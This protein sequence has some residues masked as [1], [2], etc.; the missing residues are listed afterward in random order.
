MLP[1]LNINGRP[2]AAFDYSGAKAYSGNLDV[3]DASMRSQFRIS[4]AGSMVT[5]WRVGELVG[6]EVENQQE[7]FDQ[8]RGVPQVSE[9][10]KATYFY[11]NPEEFLPKHENREDIRAALAEMGKDFDENVPIPK[12][13]LTIP[14]AV[15][16]QENYE[17]EKRDRAILENA[18]PGLASFAATLGGGLVGS[19]ADPVNFIPIAN[20]LSKAKML[21]EGVSIFSRA[22]LKTLARSAAVGAGEGA[23]GALVSDAAAFPLANRWGAD[24]G[25]EDL[26]ADVG[27]GAVLGGGLSAG[28]TM[29]GHLSATWGNRKTA[30]LHQDAM[31]K[32]AADDEAGRAVDVG[33][34]MEPAVRASEE[35]A[36]SLLPPE[37]E[38]IVSDHPH[39]WSGPDR[40]PG[41]V[42]FESVRPVRWTAETPT[43]R[44]DFGLADLIARKENGRLAPQATKYAFR[45]NRGNILSGYELPMVE[46]D[47]GL[48]AVLPGNEQT[49]WEVT[50]GKGDIDHM[51]TYARSEAEFLAI[52][53]APDLWRTARYVKTE[54]WKA[55]PGRRQA[56]LLG[57]HHFSNEL[58]INGQKYEVE[59]FV[60]ETK[61]GKNY[62]HQKLKKKEEPGSV[63]GG[64]APEDGSGPHRFTGLLGSDSNIAPAAGEVKGRPVSFEQAAPDAARSSTAAPQP[65]PVEVEMMDMEARV[66]E[67]E[68]AGQ[69]NPEMR[70]ALDQAARD[71]E[72]ARQEKAGLAAGVECML[73]NGLAK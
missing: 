17:A 69:V 9:W 37:P 1:F 33:G 53:A 35:R 50:I 62:Y 7:A 36:G 66:A 21:A 10:Q 61:G 20:G 28:G 2:A 18:R 41:L 55:K 73:K 56:D 39:G 54:D 59:I 51:S 38:M 31:V 4:T 30:A 44:V 65:R 15:V 60:R 46:A 67:L 8:W 32:A 68:A 72:K 6:Q 12:E 29:L 16:Y 24:L 34:V 40:A 52:G 71:L 43:G 22:G 11:R 27:L 23:A 63:L 57:V 5:E 14:R 49:G 70:E 42:G 64:K 48:R 25:W 47:G 45:E 26:L 3:A 58:A 19:L 13:G